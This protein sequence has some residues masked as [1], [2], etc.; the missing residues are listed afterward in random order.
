MNPS[1]D[2]PQI[3]IGK[4]GRT[5]NMFLFGFENLSI[6]GRLLLGKIAN[7][8]IYDQAQVNGGVNY[9]YPGQRWVP[10]LVNLYTYKLTISVC[11]YVRL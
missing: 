8:V 5:M 4:L 1:T 11:L 2:L 9:E 3:C 10:E 7:I 6:V